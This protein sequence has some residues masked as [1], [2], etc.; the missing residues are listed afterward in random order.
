[1]STNPT[2]LALIS[3]T[4]TAAPDDISDVID[5]M[6]AIDAVLPGSDGLKWFNWLYLMVTKAVLDDPSAASFQ[7]PQWLTRLDVIFAE[8]YFAALNGFLT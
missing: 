7:N 5:V 4:T 6:T 3:I 1:M 8:F 2:D